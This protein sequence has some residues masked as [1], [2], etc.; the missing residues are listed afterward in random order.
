MQS[1]GSSTSRTLEFGIYRD[2][3]NNLDLVQSATLVQAVQQSAR[4]ETI[5]FTVQDT[6]ARRGLE[7]QGQLR[8]ESYRIADGK[9]DD[10]A[11]SPPH[12]MSSREN[13]ARF[14]AQTL[15]DAQAAG[16][17]SSWIDLVD[18]GGGD[19][20]GLQVDHGRGLMRS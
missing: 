20:G 12:D 14:V 6:T 17:R 13:L 15:D 8:T 4:D 2:G 3:D 11:V 10:V 19:G 7:P 1:I 16:A 18:H 9:L 5:E